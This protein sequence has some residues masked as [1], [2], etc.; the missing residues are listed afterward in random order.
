MSPKLQRSEIMPH[1]TF[2]EYEN[3]LLTKIKNNDSPFLGLFEDYIKDQ[4]KNRIISYLQT[5]H[6]P[7]KKYI[8]LLKKYP[9]VFSTLL[10]VQLLED[11]GEHGHFE[12]YPVLEKIFGYT[13]TSNQKEILWK[14][15]RRA[16]LFNL[17]ISVSPR[18]SGPFFMVKEYLRQVGLPLRFAE[19][20]SQQAISYIRQA[21]IPDVD[22]PE[23][24][25][26]WQEGLIERLTP[27]S[28]KKAIQRDDTC[29]FTQLFIRCFSKQNNQIIGQSKIAKL[30][31]QSIQDGPQIRTAKR[32]AIP[33]IVFRE[34]EYGILLPGSDNVNQWEISSD[35]TTRNYTSRSDERFISFENPLPLNVS[36]INDTGS[37]WNYP[38]WGDKA[39]NK[40]MIF[41]IPEGKFI[42]CASLAEHEIFIDPGKYLL[43]MRFEPENEGDIELFYDNPSLY[44]KKI[45]LGPGEIFTIHRGPAAIKLKADEKPVLNFNK[46]PLQGI[47]GNELYPAEKLTLKIIIPKEMMEANTKFYIKIKSNSLGEIVKIPFPPQ[48]E[49]EFYLD[50]G[51]VMNKYWKPGVSRILF[52]IFQKGIKRSLVRKSAVIWNGLLNLRKKI[53]FR[54]SKLPENL[55][56][57]NCENLEINTQEQ[58]LSFQDETN[59]FFKMAFKDGSKILYFTWTVPGIFLSLVD[60]KGSEMTENSISLGQI[61]SITASS[62][63][64]IKIFASEPGTLQMGI[65]SIKVDF[66]RIGYKKFTLQAS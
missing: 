59:R 40:F 1:Q 50:I 60:Y 19:R 14:S 47:R 63:K 28:V 7:F 22:D 31:T 32:A 29:Y 16:C 20:F 52:E 53:L 36:I 12:V 48:Q 8:E 64:A 56:K 23:L 54:C 34:F 55:F 45:S 62:R 35:N 65:F 10:I 46:K 44:T 39:N 42:R 58:E 11:F 51:K 38:L 57:D 61:V 4:T 33:Q 6:D 2:R 3:N 49:N 18:T 26:L 41:S 15:F 25:K 30:I 43:L 66:S 37:Q 9:A 13:M 5:C 21:G 24:I 17:G 27:Q